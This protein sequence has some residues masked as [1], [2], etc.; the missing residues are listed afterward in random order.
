MTEEV[1]KLK[2]ICHYW[3][4]SEAHSKNYSAGGLSHEQR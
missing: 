3:L 4:C 2:N 1:I